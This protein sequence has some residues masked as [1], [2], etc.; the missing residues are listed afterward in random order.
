M[1]KKLKSPYPLKL[2]K[3]TFERLLIEVMPDIEYIARKWEGFLEGYGQD[4]VIQELSIK[5]W[6]IFRKQLFPKDMVYLDCRCSRF[7][8]KSFTRRILDIKKLKYERSQREDR[9]FRDVLDT[10][11]PLD[12]DFDTFLKK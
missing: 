5:L 10:S 9:V 1:K 11:L 8:S 2:S 4:D 3:I 12:D 7:L 6:N